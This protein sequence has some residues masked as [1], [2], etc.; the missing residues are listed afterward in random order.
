MGSLDDVPQKKDNPPAPDWVVEGLAVEHTTFGR[1]VVTRVG[2]YKR[3]H[4]VWVDFEKVGEKALMPMYAM[5]HLRKATD[6]G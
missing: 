1:G 3:M 2:L 4:T 5:P 6:A